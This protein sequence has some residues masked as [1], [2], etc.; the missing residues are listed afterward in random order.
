MG[1]SD[2]FIS[3]N[4]CA[5]IRYLRA[6][7]WT[8][9]QLES[10]F[11]CSRDAILSHAKGRE[12]CSHE[13]GPP[14][15]DL[16]DELT[17]DVL[18]EA[19][20]N[21]AMGQRTLAGVMDVDKSTIAKWETGDR[22]PRGVYLER[23]LEHLPTLR[24]LMGE[25]GPTNPFPPGEPP[26]NTPPDGGRFGNSLRRARNTAGMTQAELATEVGVCS[27]TVSDW[28]CGRYTPTR[29]NL[30][31]LHDALPAFNTVPANVPDPDER[32]EGGAV[33]NAIRTARDRADITRRV[34]AGRIGV[35]EAAVESWERGDRNPSPE[36]RE[37]L[38]NALPGL[39]LETLSESPPGSAPTALSD[40]GERGE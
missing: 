24:E 38:Q 31:E 27:H 3:A 12:K 18:R 26:E 29:T 36:N 23:L 35:S 39:D 20:T 21:A 5:A 7:G 9:T 25:G 15:V 22:K 28:E 8:L 32:A 14:P 19:R 40:G 33:G 11:M 10:A 13:H 30:T 6:E 1:Q 17:G 34:L 16:A 37:R 2:R 4:E